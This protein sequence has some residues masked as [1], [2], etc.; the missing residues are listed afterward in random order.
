M[1]VAGA[2]R[3]GASAPGTLVEIGG[4]RIH[5]VCI[6]ESTPGKPTVIFESS[7]FGD[8][9]SSEKAREG[10]AAHVRVC[11]CRPRGHRM[12][13]SWPAVMSAGTSVGDLIV[14]G[15]GHLIATS[16]AE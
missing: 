13:R 9:L 15:S 8:A 16:R 14:P 7:G 1:A 4:R 3:L 2:L 10:V 12:E 5:L 6:G 11:S